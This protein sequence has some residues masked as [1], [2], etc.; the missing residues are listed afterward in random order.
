MEDSIP[1]D[2]K[3]EPE[4][5]SQGSYGC[6]YEP[7]MTCQGKVGSK[8]YVTKI[9]QNNDKSKKEMETGKIIKEIKHYEW[10]FSPVIESCEIS[11]KKMIQH[12]NIDLNEIAE[13]EVIGKEI[14]KDE[15]E[16][17]KLLFIANK[18]RYVLGKTIGNLY[19]DKVIKYI[20]RQKMKRYY[21]H[22]F[23]SLIDHHLYLLKSL[24]QMKKKQIIHYDLK[25]NNILFD[26]QMNVPIIIDFGISI[27]AN[28][29]NQENPELFLLR[30]MFYNDEEY[31]AWCPEIMIISNIIL[32][33]SL[34]TPQSQEIK[35]QE[36]QTK[37]ID[38]K[39]LSS[40]ME[41]YFSHSELF[42]PNFIY[43]LSKLVPAKSE[44]NL[45]EKLKTLQN[46]TRKNWEDYLK[47]ELEN[48]TTLQIFQTL[49]KSKYRWDTYALSTM[50]LSILTI[51]PP[52]PNKEAHWLDKLEKYMEIQI[53][54]IQSLP[55]ERKTPFQMF[56]AMKTIV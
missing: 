55:M 24:S 44:S 12:K 52:I 45:K 22:P 21:P 1:K 23:E 56:K 5:I 16:T 15:K 35:A 41:K 53:E 46:N 7:G 2:I 13:C 30:E 42:K 49:W 17:S 32:S 6:I 33:L 10:Y 50:F 20:F 51:F 18:I 29:I 43:Q 48:K 54:N 34:N 36:W 9:Q 37:I 28:L 11:L 38:S 3:N 4:L 31:L 27:Q 26:I 25:N 8:K 40:S 47:Q 39:T 19:E 14:K